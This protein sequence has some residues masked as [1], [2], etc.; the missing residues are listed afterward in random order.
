M[1]SDL[2][3]ITMF[4]PS[5]MA[6]TYLVIS[7]GPIYVLINVYQC[8]LQDSLPWYTSAGEGNGRKRTE[9]C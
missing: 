6:L 8:L 2:Y 5:A 7:K 9:D 1:V 4:L 3:R